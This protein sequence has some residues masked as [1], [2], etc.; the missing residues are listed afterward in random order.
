VKR[1]EK[2]GQE[3]KVEKLIKEWKKGVRHEGMNFKRLFQ[4]ITMMMMMMII[5][6][7]KKNRYTVN[8]EF[9]RRSS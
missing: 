4:L 3:I 7:A 5:Y 6:N 2:V 8:T 9:V 1:D